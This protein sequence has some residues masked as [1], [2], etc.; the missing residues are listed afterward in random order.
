M[1]EPKELFLHSLRPSSF[2]SAIAVGQA[3]RGLFSPCSGSLL[4]PPRSALALDATRQMEAPTAPHMY[5]YYPDV[6]GLGLPLQWEE[7]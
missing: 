4:L 7:L 1:A 6:L 3:Q 2:G 5:R